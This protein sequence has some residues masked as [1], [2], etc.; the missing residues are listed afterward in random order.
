MTT[1]TIEKR[2]KKLERNETAKQ[3]RGVYIYDS[4]M[5]IP[6]EVLASGKYMIYLPDNHR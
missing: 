1:H 3:V 4:E 5:V 6:E 2:L